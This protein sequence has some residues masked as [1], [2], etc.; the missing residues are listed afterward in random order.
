MFYKTKVYITINI[1][2]IFLEQMSQQDIEHIQ[3]VKAQFQQVEKFAEDVIALK[4][5]V[6]G[7]SQQKDLARQGWRA[8]KKRNNDKSVWVNIGMKGKK[9][10]F[11][12]NLIFL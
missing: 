1:S 2:H 8:L 6:L 7:L 10:F 9:Y 4:N 3:G 11:F 12:Q 5:H